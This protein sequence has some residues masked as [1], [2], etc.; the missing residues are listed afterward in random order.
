MRG[1]K[2]LSDRFLVASCAATFGIFSQEPVERLKAAGC[3]VLINPYG[4]PLTS[5]EILEHA[6][7]ADV[8]ILGNDFLD[9]QTIRQLPNLKMIAG[10]SG[11]QEMYQKI[12]NEDRWIIFSMTYEPEMIMQA[13]DTGAAILKDEEYDEIKI[14]PTVCVDRSNVEKY[15]DE[16]SPFK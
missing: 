2:G 8:I 10:S 9:A 15:L 1:D 6:E 4:R 16:N 14:V 3:D 13:V 12:Q 5:Q 7:G 11:S